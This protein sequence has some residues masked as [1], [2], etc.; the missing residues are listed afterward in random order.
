MCILDVQSEIRGTTAIG[1]ARC[2]DKRGN[3]YRASTNVSHSESEIRDVYS[4]R[5][6]VEWKLRGC[7]YN[8]ISDK[9]M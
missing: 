8:R 9:S 2:S 5:M 3:C 4:H 6:E 7:A 1:P